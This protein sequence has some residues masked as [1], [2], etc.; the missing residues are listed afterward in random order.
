VSVLI[1]ND[2]AIKARTASKGVI[3]FHVF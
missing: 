2:L 3:A 1:W